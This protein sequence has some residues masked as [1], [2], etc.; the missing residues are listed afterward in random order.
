MINRQDK[1][2]FY[3][4]GKFKT[5]SRTE[6]MELEKITGHSLR[7]DFNDA[8]YGACNWLVDPP[9]S[10]AEL[11]RQRAQQIRDQ[12]DYVI[13]WYSG[14]ADSQNILNSFVDNNIK[15]DEVLSFVNYSITRDKEHLTNAEIFHVAA[16]NIKKIKERQPWIKYRVEDIVDVTENTYSTD[17]GID[18][19]YDLNGFITPHS[20]GKQDLKL[21]VPEWKSMYDS[22]KKVCHVFGIEKP[23]I[24]Q[25]DGR[26][27]FHFWDRIDNAVTAKA[28]RL[29]RPWEFNE[30]F[31]WSPD[32]PELV[33]KQGH[34]IKNYLKTFTF[35][36]DNDTSNGPFSTKE[37]GPQKAI[38]E[39][40]RAAPLVISKD[41]NNKDIF[42]TY[43]TLHTLIY[44]NWQPIPFQEKTR[45]IV[46]SDKDDWFWN[47]S[48]LETAK[49]NHLVGLEEMWKQ[50]P[51]KYRL[52]VNDLKKGFKRNLS[53]FYCLGA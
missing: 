27:F 32:L 16:P 19:I 33:I 14:G 53:P 15:L 36:E 29:D 7:W 8:T 6:A 39:W 52:D 45:S 28:Q 12:Y 5:Y 11:Y 4:V 38:T 47:K 48:G 17:S 43:K 44:P 2:G 26:Y 20:L 42:L 9:V 13:L 22:G 10:L 1:F 49:R 34:V 21:R 23:I 30:L 37:W 24:R 3:Q 50:T 18:W 25:I 51:D 35:G 41:S 46:F 40:N 31:Y